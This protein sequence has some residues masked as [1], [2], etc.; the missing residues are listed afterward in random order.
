MSRSVAAKTYD[1]VRALV[2]REIP[3][4][5]ERV[6]LPI[7]HAPYRK[8]V[9]WIKVEAGIALRRVEPW[10][11]PTHVQIEPT[12]R[13]NLRCTYCPVGSESAQTGHMEL[14]VFQKLVDDVERYAL[15]LVMWGWGEPFVCPQ[16]YEMIAYAHRKGIRLISSTNGHCFADPSQAEAVVRSGLDALIVSLSGTTQ[17]A[18][19]RFR[20]GRLDTALEGTRQIVAAKRRL[21]LTTPHVQMGFIVTD[22]SEM[23]VPEITE[24]A[25]AMGVDGLSFKKMNTASVKPRSGPDE[26]VP[27]DE[28]FR[29]FQYTDGAAGRVRVQQNPCKALWHSPTLRWDGSINPCAYDFDG[30][31]VLGDVRTQSFG[32][33]W[34]GARYQAMRSEFRRE[35]ERIPICS[36]CTYAFVGGDYD[37]V[38]AEAH[39]FSP[40]ALR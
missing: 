26:A 31:R 24:M 11:W 40:P 25:K 8:I 9:N 30:E 34:T 2:R 27:A 23:Q 21:G 15:L 6:P 28:R 33:I 32:E 14:E 4:E 5:F 37:D 18:Y 36:R 19:R 7:R 35:W 16:V 22:A 38:V 29:R 10:G 20:G 12:T 17:E 39:F 13:C 1:A 3:L